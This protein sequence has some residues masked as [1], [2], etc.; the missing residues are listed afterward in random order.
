MEEISSAK[1]KLFRKHRVE[2]GS[3]ACIDGSNRKTCHL[4]STHKQNVSKC[5]RISNPGKYSDWI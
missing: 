5:H 1:G 3:G 4:G 2:V